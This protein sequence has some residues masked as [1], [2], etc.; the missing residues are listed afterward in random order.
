[1]MHR[2]LAA[3]VKWGVYAVCLLGLLAGGGMPCAAETGGVFDADRGIDA[4][5]MAAES[6]SAKVVNTAV[7]AINA[8]DEAMNNA[9][10]ATAPPSA[11]PTDGEDTREAITLPP[12]YT[13]IPDALPEDML[14]LLPDGLFSADAD[15]AL[16]AAE[17]LTDWTYLLSAVLDAV[18][19]HLSGATGLLATLM[20][21]V[22]I[23][24]ILGKLREAI[25]GGGGDICGL[26]LRMVVYAAVITE[27]VGALGAVQ[28]YFARLGALTGAMIP[29]MG[30]LYALGGNLGQAAVTEELLLV[31]L[32]ICEYVSAT[33]TPPVCAVCLAG[34][35]IEAMG[36]RLNFS[37]M[38]EQIKKWYTSLLGL[39]MFGL[40]LALS[41]QS[42]LSSRADT[43]AMRGA[44]YAVGSML[45]TVG[46]AVAGMLGTVAE[47]VGYLRGICGVAGVILVLLLLLPTVVE[48]LLLRAVLRLG[49]T[50]ATLLGCDSEA[51]LCT[52]IA[53]LYGYLVAAA[54]IVSILFLFALTLLMHASTAL[55]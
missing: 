41:T 44:K 46:G 22:L 53:S 52:A 55:A 3:F 37:A 42:V 36:S 54:S 21:L 10:E 28:A 12:A 23:A 13:A 26:C 32:A 40:S 39:V 27:T 6:V 18:G 24:A 49:A 35:L 15:E 16:S 20:G 17:A 38:A 29:A 9:T 11:A 48:L 1:M 25:G 34:A 30:G 5:I 31:F 2:V 4:T 43:L 51:R 14:P 33:A 8:G 19:L 7:E 47:S 50:A 45:P